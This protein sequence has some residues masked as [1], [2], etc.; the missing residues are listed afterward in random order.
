MSKRLSAA[1]LIK[2]INEVVG[3]GNPENFD[4]LINE[5]NDTIAVV[6]PGTGKGKE[7]AAEKTCRLLID[8]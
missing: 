1:C 5:R 7:I 6:M 2:L 4:V 8:V 3:D